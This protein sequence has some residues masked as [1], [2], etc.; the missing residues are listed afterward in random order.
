V[1]DANIIFDFAAG[2]LLDD[3]F[4]F[5]NHAQACAALEAMLHA[6]SRLPKTEVSNLRI[7]WGCE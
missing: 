1:L 4:R 7:S 2:G 5:I 3:L 6:G